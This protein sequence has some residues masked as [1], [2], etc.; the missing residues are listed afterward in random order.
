MKQKQKTY[1]VDTS[2]LIDEPDIFYKLG[3][4]EIVVPIAV[5]RE[6]DGLKKSEVPATAASA[7][8]V[9]RTL[10]RLGNTQ[11]IASGA[12]T[13]AGSTVMICNRYQTVNDLASVADN[14]IVGTALKLNEKA[15]SNVIML[16]T[17]SNMR[18]VARAHGLRAEPYPFLNSGINVAPE[19]ASSLAPS[20]HII[21]ALICA[22][23]ALYFLLYNAL[24]S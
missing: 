7:R 19:V 15:E 11:N 14:K 13:S 23:L 17:G 20:W 6:L 24:W 4:S 21:T 10:D 9:S 16:T 1:V 3:A 8:K 2:V 22:V 12:R 5:V 18:N